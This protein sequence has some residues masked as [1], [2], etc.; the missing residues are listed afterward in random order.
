MSKNTYQITG[1]IV[2]NVVANVNQVDSNNTKVPKRSDGGGTTTPKDSTAEENPGK[3]DGND[4]QTQKR[5]S[6]CCICCILSFALLAVAII[7]CI[8]HFPRIIQNHNLGFDYL[9]LIV[10]ILAFLVALLIG[11]QIYNTINAKHEFDTLEKKFKAE[12]EG[13]IK[14]LEE[15]CEERKN[16]ISEIKKLQLK[17]NANTKRHLSNKIKRI[18]KE[19]ERIDNLPFLQDLYI[20][21]IQC[22]KGNNYEQAIKYFLILGKNDYDY[23]I[24]R[25]SVAKIVKILSLYQNNIK[26]DEIVYDLQDLYAKRSANPGVVDPKDL[27]FIKRY[28]DNKESHTHTQA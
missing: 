20:K 25:D 28:L 4:L 14:R 1:N 17:E 16:E 23:Y 3:S 22:E 15:C 2:A 7:L 24:I 21:A 6:P 13:R 5:K 8:V 27:E 9:G 10:G 26:R 19:I 18:M 12:Y 11:W